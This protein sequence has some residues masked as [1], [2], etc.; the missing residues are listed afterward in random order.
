MRI[1]YFTISLL[2]IVTAFE[3]APIPEPP[4]PNISS[5]LSSSNVFWRGQQAS[6]GTV[7]PCIRIPSLLQVGEGVLLA[8]A[9]CRLR[10]QD[11]CFPDNITMAGR[12]DICT[13]KSTDNGRSWGAL[14]VIVQGAAQNT[15]AYDAARALV[16]LNFNLQNNS[17]A[18]VVSKDNGDAWGPIQSLTTYLGPLDGASAGPGVGIQLSQSNPHH[19]GRLLFIGHRGAYVEDV[20]WYS[21]DNG[22]TYSLAATPAGHTLPGMDEAQLV[23]LANG[24]VLANM[25]N[26]AS[27]PG[28]GL[29]AV[30]LSTDGGSS[31]SAP[32]FDPALPEPVCMATIIRSAPPLGD[33][34]V[35][36]ANPGQS[37]GRINGRVRRSRSCAGLDCPWDN[38]TLVVAEGA[39]YGYSC[40]APIN[41]TH[42]GLLWE[43]GAPGCSPESSACLQVFSLIPLSTFDQ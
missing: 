36:F 2:A 5:N 29:R 12:R 39:A 14:N 19:P 30:A 28:G 9:E 4:V 38:T 23:E 17:N 43:T 24:D 6:D 1:P 8:F 11:G 22:G 15:P 35:Y 33:G 3:I 27:H 25:R 18:Q 26:N 16:I 13:R 10:T 41:E 32:S 31:F 40:L 7:Y 34:N 37:E 20:I 21:D 42:M